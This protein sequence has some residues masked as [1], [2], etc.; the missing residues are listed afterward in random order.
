[1]RTERSRSPPRS[2]YGQ[3]WY[4]RTKCTCAHA[5]IKCMYTHIDTHT[6]T[7]IIHTH[8]YTNMNS[9]MCSSSCLYSNWKRRQRFSILI[10]FKT[11]L[12][13][14]PFSSPLLSF[15][16]SFSFSFSSSYLFL[17]SFSFSFL[18]VLYF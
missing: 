9:H 10:L 12:H 3:N 8:I 13:F 15:S 18:S 4:V 11:K 6:N 1:M 7:H 14:I 16:F 2:Q 17:H 5:C